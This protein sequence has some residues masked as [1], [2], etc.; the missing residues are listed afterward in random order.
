MRKLKYPKKL[1]IS[2]NALNM[3][4]PYFE[5]ERK[6]TFKDLI[7]LNLALNVLK[8]FVIISLVYIIIHLID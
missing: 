5:R 3:D 7:D 8:A 2:N 1:N 4:A 6:S